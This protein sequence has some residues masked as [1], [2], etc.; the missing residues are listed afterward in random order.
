MTLDRS[1][2]FV[3]GTRCTVPATLSD[4]LPTV[5]AMAGISLMERNIPT[6]GID[7]LQVDP[8]QRRYVVGEMA[9][10][11]PKHFITDG[12]YKFLHHLNGGA[13]FFFD[14]ETDPRELRNLAN[15][16][17]SQP[18][19]ERLEEEL[20]CRLLSIGHR[21]LDGTGLWK[22]Q[23]PDPVSCVNE[24]FPGLHSNHYDIDVLH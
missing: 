12:R 4:I 2:G 9:G 18:E 20:K 13:S 16:A 23:D 6:D 11:H 21:D 22:D 17:E 7:L 15:D 1:S 3:P 5:V 14:L 24:A 8:E 19:R 10:D